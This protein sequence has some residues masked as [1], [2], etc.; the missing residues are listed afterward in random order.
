VLRD[1]RL[2]FGGRVP[3]TLDELVMLP[4]VGRKTANLVL[5]LGFKSATQHLR[6]HDTSIASRTGSAG[7]DRDA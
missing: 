7:C 2:A 4:G 6:R 1:A 3:S 5:I